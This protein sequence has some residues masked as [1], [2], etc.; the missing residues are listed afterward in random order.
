[1]RNGRGRVGLGRSQRSDVSSHASD[2]E[3]T[4]V[5]TSVIDIS[6][7]LVDMGPSSPACFTARSGFARPMIFFQSL[8]SVR[9]FPI[10]R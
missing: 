8:S 7:S 6:A 3:H 1:L 5:R 10:S 9:E 4:I 2:S